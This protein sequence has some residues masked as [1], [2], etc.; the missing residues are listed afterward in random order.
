MWLAELKMMFSD[1]KDEY[2]IG[3]IPR[4]DHEV[5]H[6]YDELVEMRGSDEGIL[7]VDEEGHVSG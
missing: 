2:E 4:D 6:P 3:Q 7:L 1:I 5:K